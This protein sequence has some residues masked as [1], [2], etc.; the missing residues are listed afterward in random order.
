[1]MEYLLKVSFVIGIAL[2]FYKFVLHQE[3]FFS[4]NRIYLLGCILL[5]FALPFVTVPQFVSHQ[6]YL[7]YVFQQESQPEANIEQEAPAVTA[8]LTYS[9]TKPAEDLSLPALPQQTPTV[10][11]EMAEVQEAPVFSWTQDWLFLLA[12]LY[13][14]GVVVFTLHLLVQVGSILYK[15]IS[16]TDKVQDGEYVIVNTE[17]RQAPCSFFQYIFIYPDDYD[18]ATYEQIIAHEKAHVRQGHSL[19]LLIAELAVIVLWFNPLMWLYK[20]EIEKNMEYQTDAILLEK[21]QVD[22]D[23]YQLNLLQIACPNKP[24]SITINYNQSLLKQRIIMMN[25][26]KSTLHSYWKYAFLAPLFFGIILFMNEPAISQG[27]PQQE[28]AAAS[29]AAPPVPEKEPLPLPEQI[30]A[31]E[32]TPVKMLAEGGMPVIR[33]IISEV[34]KEVLSE[35][36][37]NGY[38]MNING[39]QVDMSEGYWYSNQEGGEYCL[40]FKGSKNTSSWNMSR[41][42]DKSL[43]QK[44]GDNLFV[45]T[46]ETGTLQLNGNLDA[47]VGQGKYTFTEDASFKKYL[48]DNNITSTNKN[49]MFHLFFGDVSKQYVDY[50]KKNYNEVEGER[51]L[52]LAIHGVSMNDFQ[53][54]KALFQKYS[55]KTPSIREVVEARIHGIDEAYVQELEGAG[56]KGLPLRKMMEAKIHNVSAS[57]IESLQKA[58]FTNLAMD[59]I[60]QAKIHGMTPAR[61]KEMQGL[62]FGELSLDKMIKLQIHHVDGAFIADLKSA[63]L[64]NLTLDQMTEAKIHGLN[65]ASVKDIRALGF[66]DTSFRDMISVKIHG[67]DAAYIADLKSAGFDNLSLDQITEA[68]IHGLDAAGIKAIQTLGFK[69]MSFRE[70]VSAKI[71][72]VDAAYIEDLRKAGLQ[73]LTID[74]AVEAKIHGIDSRFIA[75]A[76]QEGYDLKTVDE[77]VRLKIHGM[78]LESLKKN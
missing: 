41:C 47:E 5:A 60:I 32:G 37:R 28:P 42:F 71:H 21:E 75:K 8:P 66:D 62:G 61:I 33:E 34:K 69:D 78:A 4:T 25:A 59:K 17:T 10:A 13:V 7:D 43:F 16:S 53:N 26:K 51:L 18:F 68:K 54:Y 40:Q 39:R 52:E 22:K 44:K 12:M 35:K 49:L 63:G 20:K 27:N 15:G 1:M 70:I 65:A 30:P 72:D 19:D 76:K 3:S 2:L 45:M 6:G 73:N 38:S 67:V 77:Y 24:L 31:P 46:K 14:F 9:T 23:L 11:A 55:N 74:K 58:G 57:Y 50:L 29:V 48:A 36:R 56:Y 64:D